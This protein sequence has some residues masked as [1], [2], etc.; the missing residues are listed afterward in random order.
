[1]WLFRYCLLSSIALLLPA[2]GWT[3]TE[4]TLLHKRVFSYPQLVKRFY[5]NFSI[6]GYSIVLEGS[7]AQVV[8]LSSWLDEIAKIPHGRKTIKAI[9]NS[10]NQLTIRHSEAALMASGRTLAPISRNLTNNQGEDVEILFETRIPAEGSHWV[11]NARHE[12]IAFTAIQNLYHELVHAKHLM[13]GSWRYFDSEGQAIEEENSF[14]IQQAE[15][16]GQEDTSLRVGMKGLQ[17]W[18][19]ESSVNKVTV[20]EE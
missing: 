6:E 7:P 15:L 11:F 17:Y 10:G 9:V 4:E 3:D 1:M 18:W 14:R 8:Q 12:K 16:Q 5:F 2:A 19:P 13:N 20:R